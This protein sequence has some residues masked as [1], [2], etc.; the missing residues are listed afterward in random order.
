MNARIFNLCLLIGWGM[1]VAGG[2]MWNMA[3]GLAGGG[4]LLLLIVGA[5]AHFAGVYLPKSKSDG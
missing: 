5:V 1:A 2:C 3:A 4:L